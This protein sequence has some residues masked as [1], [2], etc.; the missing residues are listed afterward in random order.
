VSIG[1]HFLGGWWVDANPRANFITAMNHESEADDATAILE[2]L[3]CEKEP[4]LRQKDEDHM[5]RQ[6]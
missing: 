1:T 3:Q 5:G 6:L 4:F 2:V